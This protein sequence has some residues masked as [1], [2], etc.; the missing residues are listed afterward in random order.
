[1]MGSITALM[2]PHVAPSVRAE[3]SWLPVHSGHFFIRL[4]GYSISS[5]CGILLFPVRY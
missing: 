5:A 3:Y 2:I 1:M 4:Q